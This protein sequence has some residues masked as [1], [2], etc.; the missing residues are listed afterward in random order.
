MEYLN[1]FFLMTGQNVQY[2]P[3][4]YVTSPSV[5][6]ISWFKKDTQEGTTLHIQGD[7]IR[8]IV[9][10]LPENA[11]QIVFDGLLMKCTAQRTDGGGMKKYSVWINPN[12][13]SHC[14]AV[15]PDCISINFYSGSAVLVCNKLGDFLKYLFEHNKRYK[16]R[17]KLSYG[18]NKDNKKA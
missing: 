14:F 6:F 9:D 15:Q 8:H 5:D 17:K 10:G 16:E 13:I 1:K 4:F 18:K 3:E 2:K 12:N 11:N 7:K